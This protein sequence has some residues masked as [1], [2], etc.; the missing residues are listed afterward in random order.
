MGARPLVFRFDLGE[1]VGEAAL[2]GMPNGKDTNSLA[3]DH[4]KHAVGAVQKDANLLAIC[5]GIWIDRA[6]LRIGLQRRD[7][8]RSR[9]ADLT[10]V[11]AEPD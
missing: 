7:A 8:A 3:A 11:A 5:L 4:E 6:S 9:R 10:A 1:L 2:G